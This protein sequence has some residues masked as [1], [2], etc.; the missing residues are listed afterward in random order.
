MFLTLLLSYK[1][2]I[3]VCDNFFLVW[4]AT[5]ALVCCIAFRSNPKRSR[6]QRHMRAPLNLMTRM[7]YVL[8]VM[9]YVVCVFASWCDCNCGIAF[10]SSLKRSRSLFMRWF[11]VQLLNAVLECILGVFVLSMWP[12]L[13]DHYFVLSHDLYMCMCARA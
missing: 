6:R 13:I 2:V 9:C 8:V 11:T 1:Y 7:G 3:N 10:R 5:L 12:A 4:A